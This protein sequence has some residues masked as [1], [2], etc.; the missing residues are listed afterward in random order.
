MSEYVDCM[1]RKKDKTLYMYQAN[2]ITKLE[3]QFENEIMNAIVGKVPST[4]GE[5][6]IV[7]QDKKKQ[8]I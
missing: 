8:S 4:P 6:I 7:N 3:R 1:V 5:G 2:L